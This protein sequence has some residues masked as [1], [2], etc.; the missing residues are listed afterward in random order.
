MI[1][2][3]TVRPAVPDMAWVRSFRCGPDGQNCVELN[4]AQQGQVRIRDSKSREFVTF[5][6]QAWRAFRG[7]M[8]GQM[9]GVVRWQAE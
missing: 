8:A 5:G 4:F 9:C 2:N 1:N 3:A 7:G 6:R